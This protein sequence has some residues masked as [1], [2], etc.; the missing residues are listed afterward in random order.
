ML[1]LN[2]KRYAWVPSVDTTHTISLNERFHLLRGYF[3]TTFLLEPSELRMM[4]M[5]FFRLFIT[6][7]PML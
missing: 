7:P 1:L 6:L 2:Q 5:P 4:L 3:T